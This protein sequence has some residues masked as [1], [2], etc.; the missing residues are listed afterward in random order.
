LSTLQVTRARTRCIKDREFAARGANK[1]VED[2]VP[3]N[4]IAGN[5]T[6]IAYH[7]RD[8]TLKSR[9]TSPGSIKDD[10]WL[11]PGKPCNQ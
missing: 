5:F 2:V 3:V 7:K 6:R 1:T 4:E 11:R 9:S 8:G 10:D